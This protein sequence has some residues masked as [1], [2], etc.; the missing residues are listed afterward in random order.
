MNDHCARWVVSHFD[1]IQAR[2]WSLML[3]DP[4]LPMIV[5]QGLAYADRVI[6]LSDFSLKDAAAYYPE[7]A[8]DLAARAESVHLG[9]TRDA[10]GDRFGVAFDDNIPS[11]IESIIDGGQYVVVL[12]NSFPHKQ[13]A[14]A[15]RALESLEVPV[16]AFGPI[17]GLSETPARAIATSGVLSNSTMERIIGGAALVIFPSAYEGYGLPL[18]DSLDFGVPVIAFDTVVSREVVDELG[19]REAVRFFTRFDELALV[20]TTALG[21]VGLQ[22]A[23]AAM[24]ANVRGLDPYADRLLEITLQQLREP[25]DVARLTA[26]YES[27]KRMH[28]LVSLRLDVFEHMWREALDSESFKIGHRI[29][30]LIA[31]VAR[32]FRRS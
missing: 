22:A 2:S 12:G 27:I 4:M 31:P 26:R 6:T 5:E 20:V 9:S 24:R 28:R 23:A 13:V 21:D 19:G 11:K 3:R 10:T 17:E 7:L 16:I 18:P 25:L 1:L 30:K 15:A 29:V 32:L 14:L 8:Q